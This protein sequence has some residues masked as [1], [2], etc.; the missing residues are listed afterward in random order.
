[1]LRLKDQITE[2]YRL[3][4]ECWKFSEKTGLVLSVKR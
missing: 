2:H 1:M 4:K 3:V